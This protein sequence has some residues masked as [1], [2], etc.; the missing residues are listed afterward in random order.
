MKKK[1]RQKNIAQ[2]KKQTRSTKDQKKKRKKEIGKISEKE[3]SVTIGKMF[4]NLEKRMDKMKR[5]NQQIN[6]ITKDI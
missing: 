3:F 1:K 5:S 4:Q 6:T 2:M